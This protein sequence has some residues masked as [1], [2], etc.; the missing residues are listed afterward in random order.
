MRMLVALF[1]GLVPSVAAFAQGPDPAVV[2]AMRKLS[3][4]VG[5]WQGTSKVDYGNFQSQA[6]GTEKIRMAQNGQI[7]RLEGQFTAN[8][9]GKE[10]VVHDALGVITYDPKAKKY[11]L[12]AF[13]QGKYIP[14]AFERQPDG[15]VWKFHDDT[16]NVD[17]R[18]VMTLKDG[19]W[20]EKGYAKLP[21]GP[22]REFMEMR[23]RKK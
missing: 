17:L 1:V 11:Q 15:F 4:M 18:F 13:R 16:Q 8:V 2:E 19:E 7:I 14:A 9:G 21:Q 3:F 22:E 6:K 23:L 10:R 5:D 12:H 20:V